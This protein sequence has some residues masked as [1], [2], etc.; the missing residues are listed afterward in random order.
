MYDIFYCSKKNV[1][2]QRWND[3]KKL[4]PSAQ[5]EEYVKDFKQVSQRSFTKNFW[6]IWDDLILDKNFDL[7]GYRVTK[8]DDQYIHVFDNRGSYDG[9]ALFPKNSSISEKELNSRFY[10]NKKEI[11]ITVSSPL[12]YEKFFIDTYEDYL[13]CL[14]KTSFEMFWVIPKEIEPFENFKFDFYISHNDIYNRSINHVFENKVNDYLTNYNGIMLLSKNKILGKKEI[15]NRFLIEKKEHCGVIS[16]NINEEIYD[17]VFISYKEPNAEKN[18]QNLQKRFPKIKRIDG[19]EGIHNAHIAAAKLVESEMFWVVDGDSV[20]DD[21][22]KFNFLVAR[23]EKDVVHVWQSLNPINDLKYGYGGIKLLPTKL[24][25]NMNVDTT[26]MTTS[27]GKKFKPIPAVSNITEFNTDP[28][29]T[30]RSAFRECVKL[31]SKVIQGQIDEETNARL[32]VWC[33]TARGD[34]AEYALQGARAGREYG[35]KFKNDFESL[36]KIN[37]FDWLRKLYESK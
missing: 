5:K 20:V 29:S 33:N 15:D 23:H 12:P 14:E 32:E 35:E 9:I 7:N 2:D 31:S 27:I 11:N 1:N 4:Y 34:Y 6:I 28:F 21:N 16:K 3:F 13:E 22:F 17:I 10:N 25:L 36:K 18:F 26:D 37:D 30:W 19:V 8:W 24:T